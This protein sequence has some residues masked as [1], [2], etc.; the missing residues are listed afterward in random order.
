MDMFIM[1]SPKETSQ[2]IICDVALTDPIKPYFELLPQ[3]A[4]MTEKTLTELIDSIINK[5]M[6]EFKTNPL[7]L[8]GIKNHTII[9]NMN[10]NKGDKIKT[11]ML[12]WFG[13][14]GSLRK[15]LIPSAK[16]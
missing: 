16:G 10:I 12:T 8:K 11:K 14:N 15:S 5:L 3:P 7:K 2:L 13:T 1:I 6:L 4:I 9:D